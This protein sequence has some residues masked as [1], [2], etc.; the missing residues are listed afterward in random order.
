MSVTMHER[1]DSAIPDGFGS[2]LQQ[3]A[4]NATSRDLTDSVAG[5]SRSAEGDYILS[6][7]LRCY[8]VACP[9]QEAFSYLLRAATSRTDLDT[10][11]VNPEN[12]Q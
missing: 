5:D 9:P 1:Q 10:A 4:Y 12:I 2:L 6:N 8:H 7:S 11:R 3:Y